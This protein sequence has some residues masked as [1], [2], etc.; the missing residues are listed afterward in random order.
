MA[1][2]GKQPEDNVQPM[3]ESGRVEATIQK[4]IENSTMPSLDVSFSE[5]RRMLDNQFDQ[6]D[7]IGVKVSVIVAASGVVITIILN[8]LPALI[9]HIETAATILIALSVL[10]GLVS[11]IMG[12]IVLAFTDYDSVPSISKLIQHY[13]IQPE[14]RTKYQLLHEMKD[15][16]NNNK[17]L[18]DEKIDQGWISM[19]ALL[20]SIS[21]SGIALIYILLKL[22]FS[23]NR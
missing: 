17:K 6:I 2:Q 22:A 15:A 12:L 20:L 3:S 4:A 14:A 9:T 23:Q 5:A 18:L 13:L 16:F 11:I 19:W 21:L 8:S 10:S 1:T 7:T